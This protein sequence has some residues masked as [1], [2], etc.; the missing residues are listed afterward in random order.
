VK[1]K[2]D[3]YLSDFDTQ[4][5]ILFFIF[6]PTHKKMNYGKRT[7]K[8]ICKLH[9]PTHKPKFAKEFASPTHPSP[10]TTLQ[11]DTKFDDNKSLK[12]YFV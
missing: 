12:H 3:S 6:L 1:S 5:D 8:H 9:K 4:A 11:V 10:P 2:N 7:S